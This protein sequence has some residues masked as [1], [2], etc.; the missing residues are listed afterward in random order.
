MSGLYNSIFGV[1]QRAGLMLHIL[2]LKAEDFGRFRDAYPSAEHIVVYTRCGGGNR[3]DYGE[4][5]EK[6]EKHPLFDRDED[7]DFDCTYCSFYFKHP[8]G[9]EEILK[10]MA[11]GIA[12]PAEKMITTHLDMFMSQ[13]AKDGRIW[14]DGQDCYK[15]MNDDLWIREAGC[16]GW[17]IYTEQVVTMDGHCEW[18]GDV[19]TLSTEDSLRAIA[20]GKCIGNG[21]RIFKLAEDGQ[22]VRWDEVEPGEFGWIFAVLRDLQG[23]QVVIDP[24]HRI[25][26]QREHNGYC[27]KA[28][29]YPRSHPCKGCQAMTN[30]A[31]NLR[32]RG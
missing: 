13:D 11:E 1:D 4:V 7:D 15:R 25:E 24:S 14:T 19:N 30:T 22:F 31:K 2:G 28:G 16:E 26:K 9:A 18:L 29:A 32:E 17:R 12:T 5:F 27:N 20:D 6:M 23:F 3:D 21:R 8:K 10:S